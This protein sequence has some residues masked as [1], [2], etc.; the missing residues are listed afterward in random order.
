MTKI[1]GYKG[2]DKGLKC[3]GFQFEEGKEYKRKG[4]IEICKSG[5]HFCENPF[6]VWN[7]YGIITSEFAEIESMGEVD[8]LKEKDSDTK[9]TTSRIRIVKKIALK[10]FIKAGFNYISTLAKISKKSNVTAGNSAHSST[11][12]YCAHS[13]TAG[14]SA[15]SST[16][17]KSAH[18]STAGD[19]AHSSTAG[20]FA[21]SSTAGD[22]AHSSTAGEQCISA[23]LGINNQA[24][25]AL[26]SWL[27]LS[28]WEKENNK[29]IITTVKTVKVDGENI[30]ADTW[31]EL[32]NGEFVEV[33]Q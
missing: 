13:S 14:D 15:H 7:Y 25:A 23:G 28:E 31:Y 1:K 4:E 16:A 22:S 11:A 21:H 32:E 18:S 27:V 20:D 5:F 33:K 6:D 17:G 29:W 10:E 24:K 12:G 19:P 2:F 8:Q 30:K 26:G 3:K 9:R